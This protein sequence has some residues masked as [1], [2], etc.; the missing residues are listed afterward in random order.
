MKALKLIIIIF[1][2][3]LSS[4]THGLTL[5]SNCNEVTEG[6][7]SADIENPLDYALNLGFG[8]S[9]VLTPDEIEVFF[10]DSN[11]SEAIGYHAHN[12]DTAEEQGLEEGEFERNIAYIKA[13]TGLASRQ[14]TVIQRISSNFDFSA[15]VLFGKFMIMNDS[16]DIILDDSVS[17]G[18]PF[19]GSSNNIESHVKANIEFGS[20]EAPCVFYKN[21]G[22]VNITD[23]EDHEDEH[24]DGQTTG[25][26]SLTGVDDGACEFKIYASDGSIYVAPMNDTYEFNTKEEYNALELHANLYT[27]EGVQV[28]SLIYDFK[29][30][31][32]YDLNGDLI[33]N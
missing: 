23:D 11:C 24:E 30:F 7:Y 8:D 25:T 21:T 1:V 19:N 33:T 22:T 29:K 12:G 6:L 16:Y 3:L 27:T 26:I 9:T 14:F 31:K 4:L 5:S 15:W 17:S 2:F 20:L 13:S 32:F 10:S 18:D 28:G